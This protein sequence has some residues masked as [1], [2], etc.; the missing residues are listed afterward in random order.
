M[1][2]YLEGGIRNMSNMDEILSDKD[3]MDQ[4]KKSGQKDV[5]S[6]DFEELAKELKI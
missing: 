3:L 2:Y 5:K 4:I 1:I 6:R